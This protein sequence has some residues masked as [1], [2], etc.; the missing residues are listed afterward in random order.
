MQHSNALVG[1]IATAT[2]VVVAGTLAMLLGTGACATDYSGDLTG[3]VAPNYDQFKG[4]NLTATQA[5]VS[6][7]LERRCGT[8]DCH[9]Q[10]GRPMR[11]YGQLGLRFVDDAGDYPGDGTATTETEY[12]ANYQAV[13]G[14]QPEIMS[15]VVQFQL[16]PEALMLLRKP[17]Q[18]ERHKGGAVFVEGDDTYNCITS[19]LG[20]QTDY[21]SCGTASSLTGTP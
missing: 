14:L 4:V 10:V 1:R 7:V 6:R 16:P 3:V 12:T 18:L 20:G 15:R 8:L 11:I 9:G 17:L 19:W 13:I 2:A 5:G 21:T